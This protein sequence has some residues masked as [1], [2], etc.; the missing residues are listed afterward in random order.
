MAAARQGI[1][2]EGRMSSCG[3]RKYLKLLKAMS[4]KALTKLDKT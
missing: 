2:T 3:G 1:S 4:R